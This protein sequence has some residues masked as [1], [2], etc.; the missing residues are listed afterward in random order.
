MPGARPIRI[1]AAIG[2]LRASRVPAATMTKTTPTTLRSLACLGALSILLVAPVARG[3]D[4]A[5][6]RRARA[7]FLMRGESPAVLIASDRAWV[8]STVAEQ[9]LS[10]CAGARCRPV[11]RVEACQTPRCPGPGRIATTAGSVADVGGYP[12]DAAGFEREREALLRDPALAL[13]ASSLGTMPPSPPLRWMRGSGD[14]ELGFEISL[15]A[16]PALL[17]Y[18][19]IP[20]MDVVVGGGIRLMLDWR[21]DELGAFLLGSVFGGDLR[22]HVIPNAHGRTLDD[23]AV[24]VGIA[25]VILAAPRHEVFRFPSVWGV[26]I[27][28]LGGILRGGDDVVGYAAWNLPFSLLLDDHAALEARATVMLIDDWVEGDDV[29]TLLSASLA[30]VLR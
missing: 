28:E 17:A 22:V 7:L 4:E 14:E 2:R 29:E 25:P 12:D 15:A 26:M 19:G 27:P 18:A 23:F 24:A 16:G 6:P 21:A 13:L 20:T 30:L 3:E 5:H 10:I 8:P 9:P 11:L 1:D